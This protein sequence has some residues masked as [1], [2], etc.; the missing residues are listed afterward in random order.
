MILDTMGKQVSHGGVSKL[1]LYRRPIE[2]RWK[3]WNG[4]QEMV[5]NVRVISAGLGAARCA[6][7]RDGSTSRAQ[8]SRTAST[9]SQLARS[10]RSTKE[11]SSSESRTHRSPVIGVTFQAGRQRRLRRSNGRKLVEPR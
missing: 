4:D 7:I 11:A 8:I 1:T 3:V 5:K 6:V 10:E 2:G 9:T